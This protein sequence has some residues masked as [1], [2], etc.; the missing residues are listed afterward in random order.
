MG[1]SNQDGLSPPGSAPAREAKSGLQREL[2]QAGLE[3][4]RQSSGPRK[5]QKHLP[6][7]S[8]MQAFYVVPSWASAF[9]LNHHHPRDGQRSTQTLLGQAMFPPHSL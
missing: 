7:G 1:G 2:A 5:G 9:P 6:P 4:Q 3:A 8:G